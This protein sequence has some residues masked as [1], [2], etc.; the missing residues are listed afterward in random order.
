MMKKIKKSLSTILT[1]FFV[2][3]MVVTAGLPKTVLAQDTVTE[4]SYFVVEKEWKNDLESERPESIKVHVLGSDDSNR[5]YELSADNN[6]KQELTLP[7]KSGSTEIQYSVYEETGDLSKYNSNATVTQPVIIENKATIKENVHEGDKYEV[8][9]SGLNSV[10]NGSIVINSNLEL[11][12]ADIS[13]SND[14]FE[15]GNFTIYG[16]EKTI[17]N[18][19]PRVVYNGSLSAGN[20]SVGNI[21]MTWPVTDS[22]TPAI[23]TATGEKY[24][25]RISVSDINIY[26]LVDVDN[27]SSVSRYVAILANQNNALHLQ[28]YIGPNF[29]ESNMK[30]NIVGVKADV[31]I[32]LLDS[33]DQPVDGRTVFHVVD[34]DMPDYAHYYGSGESQDLSNYYGL[35]NEYAESVEIKD[36]VES[37]IYINN[38]SF[39]TY[40]KTDNGIKLTCGSTPDETVAKTSLKYLA[41]T[42]EFSYTWR[43]S[44]CGTRIIASGGDPIVANTTNTITNISSRYVVWYYYQKEGETEPY[45]ATEPDFKGTEVMIAPGTTVAVT[46]DDKTPDESR[47]KPATGNFVLDEGKNTEWSGTTSAVDAKNPLVL[48]VYFKKTYTVI[49][50][51]NVEDKVWNKDTQTTTDIAYGTETPEFNGTPSRPGYT[52]EGWSETPEGEILESIPEIVKKDADYWAHWAPRTDTKYKV[53]YFYE[54][55]GSYPT[56]PDFTSADRIGTTD[57]TVSIIESDKNPDSSKPGYYLNSNMTSE[58]T[59]VVA[60]DGSLILKVYFKEKTKPASG[61]YKAPVTGVE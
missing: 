52:F 10:P 18:T 41:N 38:P 13:Y 46:E 48:K 58:W 2:A 5:V 44:N 47:G 12:K 11:D 56:T 54:R 27:S 60:G 14:N 39:L 50:H 8:N 17:T 23:N 16:N 40:T 34:I 36:G 37:D 35:A 26:S 59:G 57:Q 32:E 20:N 25:V 51:D 30:R 19:N 22:L 1:V 42:E 31:A 61:T 3:I 28:S 21:V 49:Y 29:D 9:N 53:Q 43:G 6:W 45:Y 33:S 4:Y 24:K 15:F 7:A 55:N